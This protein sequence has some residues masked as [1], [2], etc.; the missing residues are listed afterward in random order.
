L[1]GNMDSVCARFA[2]WCHFL[3]CLCALIHGIC[4]PMGRLKI[5]QS[6]ERSPAIDTALNFHRGI[7]RL[8]TGSVESQRDQEITFFF[9]IRVIVTA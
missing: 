8:Y 2:F 3:Q 1:K 5:R 9:E 7:H 4:D 6:D